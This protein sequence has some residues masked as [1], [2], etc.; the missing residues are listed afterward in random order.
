[1]G[2]HV[3]LVGAFERDERGAGCVV[4]WRLDLQQENERG[5]RYGGTG[6]DGERGVARSQERWKQA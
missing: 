1:M 4:N 6:D 5:W 2:D 3:L